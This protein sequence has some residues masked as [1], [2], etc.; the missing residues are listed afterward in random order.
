M[1]SSKDSSK[2]LAQYLEPTVASFT[3][4]EEIDVMKLKG[5]KNSKNNWNK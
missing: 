1:R 2:L 5:S 3:F 4:T